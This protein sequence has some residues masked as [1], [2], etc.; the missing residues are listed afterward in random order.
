MGF[1]FTFCFSLQKRLFD[2]R[3]QCGLN[4]MSCLFYIS[5]KKEKE[6]N[7]LLP[8]ISMLLAD[9]HL[10]FHLWVVLRCMLCTCGAPVGDC[11]IRLFLLYFRIAKLFTVWVRSHF[12][13]ICSFLTL[14]PYFPRCHGK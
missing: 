6:S 13:N 14:W 8:N 9:V 2:E 3:M 11:L 12:N 4:S 1:Y 10:V 5:M 7:S